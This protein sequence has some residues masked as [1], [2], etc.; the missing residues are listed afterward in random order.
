MATE[1]LGPQLALRQGAIYE[2]KAKNIVRLV[3]VDNEYCAYVVLMNSKPQMHGMITGFS[4]RGAFLSRY[5][6]VANSEADWI[7]GSNGTASADE[8]S[9]IQRRGPGAYHVA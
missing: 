1:A 3:S 7:T 5:A 4:K 8:R 6:W 2:D 9:G